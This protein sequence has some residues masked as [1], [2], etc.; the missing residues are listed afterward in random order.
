MG[1][2]NSVQMNRSLK[3]Q[4]N[5]TLVFEGVYRAPKHLKYNYNSSK[6]SSKKTSRVSSFTSLKCAYVQCP[7]WCLG[8]TMSSKEGFKQE[9]L[10]APFGDK[11]DRESSWTLSSWS[12]QCQE[13]L[14]S[15]CLYYTNFMKNRAWGKK[16]LGRRPRFPCAWLRGCGICCLGQKWPQGAEG[17]VECCRTL[18]NSVLIKCIT[19]VQLRYLVS[20]KV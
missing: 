11:S 16:K 20:L 4:N 18:L 10:F 13:N 8:E 19:G 2:I 5:S 9:F 3:Q 17:S 6:R 15:V 12:F 7:T 1:N 14:P